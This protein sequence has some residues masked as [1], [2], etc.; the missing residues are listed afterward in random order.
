MKRRSILA[1]AVAAAGLFPAAAHAVDPFEIQVYEGDINA[2]SQVGLEV[3][4][5]VVPVG[6]AEPAFPGEVVPDDLMRLTFEPSYGVLP[7]WELGAY[8]QFAMQPDAR[9]G[10]FGGFKLRSKF[11]APRA[12]TGDFILGLNMEVGRGTTAFGSADWGSEF[13]PIF[14]YNPG[15]FMVAVNPMIG[16][17]LS[18]EGASWV[19]DFEPAFKVRVDTGLGFGAGVEYYAGIGPL[20]R[21][22]GFEE[23]E[24]IF[25]GIV[26]LV[27]FSF[28]L[29]I[30]LG[31]GLT[32]GANDWTMKTILGLGF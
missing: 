23:Q 20:S 9:A 31:R 1:A 12:K 27:G 32:R 25:Y 10:H 28:D 29:N 3:H 16:W 13:R 24:H 2:Q 17:G 8:L 30:G 18:G 4:G 26:D 14:V 22:P 11:V 21:T 5:N 6:R 19:P 7:W 15:P